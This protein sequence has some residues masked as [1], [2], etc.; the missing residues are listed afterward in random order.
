MRVAF[1]NNRFLNLLNKNTD[2]I[3]TKTSLNDIFDNVS[4]TEKEKVALC[5][6]KAQVEIL[7]KSLRSSDPEKLRAYNDTYSVFLYIKIRQGFFKYQAL[8]IF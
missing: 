5:L 8:M 1:N 4:S 6:N 3:Q 7:M 2:S